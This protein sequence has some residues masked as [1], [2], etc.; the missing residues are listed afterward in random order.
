MIP[1]DI[2]DLHSCSLFYLLLLSPYVDF[3]HSSKL[4]PYLAL[5][6]P[7]FK[8]ILPYCCLFWCFIFLPPPYHG[9]FLFP[10]IFRRVLYSLLKIWS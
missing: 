10:C 9:S 7:F 4:T 5:L 2:L 3:S 6:I 1:Y 8:L